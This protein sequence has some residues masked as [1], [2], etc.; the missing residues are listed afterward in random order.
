MQVSCRSG[1]NN[2][3]PG[4]GISD[5]QQ[6][7]R[8]HLLR[9]HFRVHS[10]TYTHTLGLAR[11]RNFRDEFLQSK[12]GIRNK[13]SGFENMSPI[14]ITRRLSLSVDAEIIGWGIRLRVCVVSC[15]LPCTRYIYIW[16][17]LLLHSRG[18]GGVVLR[19]HLMIGDAVYAK[20]ATKSN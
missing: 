7:R 3:D 9:M 5:E 10:Y 1:H 17:L 6:T 12:R 4:V 8:E 19:I 2:S 15:V 14:C 20:A 13:N 18:R 11:G 16:H